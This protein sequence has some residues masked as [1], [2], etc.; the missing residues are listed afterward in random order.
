MKRT[1][2]A[3]A[4]IITLS[5]GAGAQDAPDAESIARAYMDAYS[6]ANIDAMEPM[7]AQDMVFD[8]PT[9]MGEG[10]GPEGIH[11]E[12]RDA[13][14]AMLRDFIGTYNPIE[15]GFVW[16]TVFA[17]ND[18]VV[19]TGHVN[20]LYPTETEGQ[21]FRWRADQVSVITVRDGLVVHHQ[22]FANYAAPE[23]GL[24]PAQ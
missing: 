13:S 22:D 19:F 2:V 16:D 10:L 21:V 12:G 9:A 4:A 5:A 7:M 11:R 24:M 18:R 3:L 1:L 8:D 23:Q 14:L 6:A 20:A 17:S 15:L